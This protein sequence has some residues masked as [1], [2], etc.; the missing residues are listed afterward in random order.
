MGSICRL[1]YN[2]SLKG[3]TSPLF[4]IEIFFNIPFFDNRIK[5]SAF[6]DCIVSEEDLL[7]VTTKINRL[8]FGDIVNYSL[9]V[10]VLAMQIY[11]NCLPKTGISINWKR[12]PRGR[13]NDKMIMNEANLLVE[14]SPLGTSGQDSPLFYSSFNKNRKNNILIKWPAR[15]E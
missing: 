3:F 13:I 8:A 15:C 7:F 10:L 6:Y 4:T 11:V 5:Y 9:W 1:F 14:Y 2:K 12:F